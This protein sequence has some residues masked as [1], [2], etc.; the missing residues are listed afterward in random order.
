MSSFTDTAMEIAVGI[1][2]F[3]F[4]ILYVNSLEFGAACPGYVDVSN[5][6]YDDRNLNQT[7][8]QTGLTS[9]PSGVL[10]YATNYVSGA[11]SGFSLIYDNYLKPTVGFGYWLN[12]SCWFN[13][14]LGEW[15]PRIISAI[16]SICYA[17]AILF[18]IRGFGI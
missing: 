7:I 14:S 9:A 17:L 13:R 15:P 2:L 18:F 16:M 8:G 11:L 1:V 12:E 10:N 4:V 6:G 3:N 5:P